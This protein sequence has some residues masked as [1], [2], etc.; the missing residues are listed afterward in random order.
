MIS[1]KSFG[2]KHGAPPA[3]A[4]VVDCRVLR[5]P[6]RRRDLRCL[7]GLDEAVQRDVRDSPLYER[8]LDLATEQVQYQ[9]RWHGCVEVAVGCTGGRHRSVVMARDLVRR[10]WQVYKVRARV[11]HRDL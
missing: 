10:L 6:H 1:V 5:N 7:T 3:H 2:F 8:F 9:V 11:E 4:F